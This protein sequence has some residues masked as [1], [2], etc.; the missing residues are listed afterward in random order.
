MTV[1]FLL[2]ERS[3]QDVPVLTLRPVLEGHDARGA[4]TPVHFGAD[5]PADPDEAGPSALGAEG[6]G[7]AG[8]LAG[9][10]LQVDRET[11]LRGDVLRDQINLAQRGNLVL[12]R[13]ALGHPG[14]PDAARGIVPEASLH[15]GHL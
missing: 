13:R 15:N 6:E 7:L 14:Y 12:V 8:A 1:D 10:R 2:D 5:L 3:H 9:A 11:V 4:V